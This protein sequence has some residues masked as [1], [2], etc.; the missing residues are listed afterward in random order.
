MFLEENSIGIN[1][2]S[3]KKKLASLTWGAEHSTCWVPN[4]N[5]KGKEEKIPCVTELGH[6]SLAFGCQHFWFLDLHIK[7][8]TYSSSSLDSQALNPTALNSHCFFWV[9]TYRWQTLG[10]SSL[11]NHM[12]WP[13]I[14]NFSFFCH[15]LILVLSFEEPQLIVFYSWFNC[16]IFIHFKSRKTEK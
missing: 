2:L 16:F 8:G 5:Q 1:G 12:T 10:L 4:S 9:S 11:H 13:L 7:V 3:L 6:P 15:S 14:I